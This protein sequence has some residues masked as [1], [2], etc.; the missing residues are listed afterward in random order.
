[1]IINRNEHQNASKRIERVKEFKY[2]GQYIIR[3][4]ELEAEVKCRC[5]YAKAVFGK[6]RRIFTGK[7][8]QS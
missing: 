2:L 3:D 1:M 6:M 8:L 5:G 4:L 7:S